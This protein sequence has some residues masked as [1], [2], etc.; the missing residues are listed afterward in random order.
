MKKILIVEDEELLCRV[1]STALNEV[2][3]ETVV[4]MDGKTAI[5]MV[6]KEKPNLIVLDI[7]LPEISGLKVLE[8]I[9][10]IDQKVPIIMCTAY[11]TYR[12][13]YEVWSGQV[14]DY[15]TKPIKLDELKEKIRKLL[16]D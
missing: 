1:Y 10:K 4:A 7:K 15:I 2:G 8:A 16:G 6:E 14:S 3:Y 9:R 12:S 5:E 11:N 13:D